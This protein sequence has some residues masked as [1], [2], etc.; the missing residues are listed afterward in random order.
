MPIYWFETVYSLTN[1]NNTASN[2]TSQ[3]NSISSSN[4]SMSYTNFDKVDDD[5]RFKE[6]DRKERG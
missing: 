2:Y 1:E 6:D 5:S 3:G 4:N